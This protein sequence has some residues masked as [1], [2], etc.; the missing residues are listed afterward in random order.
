MPRPLRK[1]SE[2]GYYHVMIRGNGKQIIFEVR[3]DYIYFLNLLKRYTSEE[4]VK[5]CA[6]CLM[7]NHVHLLL[8]DKNDRLS[9][10]MQKIEVAYTWYYNHK[11]DR[12]GHLFQGRYTSVPIENH[13]QLLSAFRYI[14]NNPREAGICH[15][16][17]Y[18][19]CSYSRY[20]KK[21][22][23][24]DTSVFT[25]L[26]GSFKEYED[27]IDGKYEPGEMIP[28]KRNDD[29]WAKAVIREVLNGENAGVIRTFD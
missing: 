25:A 17:K 8:F 22:S 21:A 3:D 29:V 9:L 24:V 2:Y 6:F 28:E 12:Q 4:N 27:F 7:N 5:V 20:G 23:F 1:R 19:Y 18:D 11:Y 10:F 13:V 16:S 14:L 15:P 26:L